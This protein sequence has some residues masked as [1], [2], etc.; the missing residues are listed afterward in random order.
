MLR[1]LH[2]LGRLTSELR[3]AVLNTSRQP[4]HRHIS[5]GFIT[6][7]RRLPL[8]KYSALPSHTHSQ[9]VLISRYQHKMAD[10]KAFQ[11]LS[12]DVIPTNYKLKLQPDLKAF[13]FQGSAEISVQ[14]FYTLKFLHQ[15]LYYNL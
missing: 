11:R 2:Y 4:V 9:R 1:N 3:V 12:A 10:K 15:I 13:T 5:R 6:A 7:F 8:L 14:V